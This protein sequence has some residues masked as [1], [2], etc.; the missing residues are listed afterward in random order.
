MISLREFELQITIY[1]CA[2]EFE[3]QITIYTNE[4]SAREFELQ[5]IIFKWKQRVRIECAS[6]IFSKKKK[7]HL[8]N[9]DTLISRILVWFP[10]YV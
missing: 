8:F 9:I 1:T 6:D 5:V 3:L 2:G 10:A 4:I 7:F